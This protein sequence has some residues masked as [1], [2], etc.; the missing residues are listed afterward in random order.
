M[1]IDRNTQS[2]NDLDLVWVP[3]DVLITQEVSEGRHPILM[4]RIDSRIQRHRQRVRGYHLS[5]LDGGRVPRVQADHL[6]C[7]LLD[8]V[9]DPFD[10]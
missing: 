6:P 10:R 3:R 5:G 9:E 1:I 8:V 2:F 7:A 4:W